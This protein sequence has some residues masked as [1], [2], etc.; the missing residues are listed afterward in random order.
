MLRTA[1]R[2][3]KEVSERERKI[4]AKH[5]VMEVLGLTERWTRRRRSRMGGQEM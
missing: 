3:Q 4:A 1:S 2:N 5:V